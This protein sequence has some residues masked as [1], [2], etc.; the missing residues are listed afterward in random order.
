MRKKVFFKVTTDYTTEYIGGLTPYFCYYFRIYTDDGLL[1]PKNPWQLNYLVMTPDKSKYNS[2]SFSNLDDAEAKMDKSSDIII[3]INNPA[4]V[5]VN[6]KFDLDNGF[7]IYMG[8]QNTEVS[9]FYYQMIDAG[10]KTKVSKLE[11]VL[12]QRNVFQI[13]PKFSLVV[14]QNADMSNA[15]T[16]Y[17]KVTPVLDNVYSYENV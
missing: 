3:R 17:N 12:Y 15:T 13:I 7:Q 1:V 5:W 4:P 16:V 14:S 6:L 10:S 8:G 11:F 2:Q 9:N